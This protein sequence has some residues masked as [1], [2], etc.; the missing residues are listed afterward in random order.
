MNKPFN[1]LVII[2]V[3][4]I[5]TILLSVV[6]IYI[7]KKRVHTIEFIISIT[8]IPPR[9]GTLLKIVNNFMNQTLKPKHIVINVPTTYSRFK[10]VPM[11]I[12][13]SVSNHPNVI[14]N[15]I[16]QDYGPATKILGLYHLKNKLNYDYVLITDDDCMK[17]NEWCRTLITEL[18]KSTKYNRLGSIISL[19]HQN[20]WWNQK[21]AYLYGFT[22]FGIT[23]ELC[24]YTLNR[25]RLFYVR[26]MTNCF[27][28]DDDF[29]TEYYKRINLNIKTIRFNKEINLEIDNSNG[30]YHVKGDNNRERSIK[31]CTDALLV[32]H[33]P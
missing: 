12:H 1:I 8:T 19:V 25:M 28:V 21:D 26:N 22:G 24:I 18:I 10:D 23:R 6:Q 27:F 7:L 14:I 30:L 32:D 29:F 3:F 16:P 17:H 33:G 4:V 20:Q 31:K 13:E 9:A 5:Y 15:W 2:F 11:Q